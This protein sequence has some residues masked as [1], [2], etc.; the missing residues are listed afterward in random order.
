MISADGRLS[1][2]K[3]ASKAN[4]DW[5]FLQD[6]KKRGRLAADAWLKDELAMVGDRSSLDLGKSFL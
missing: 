5:S 6:L 3:L 4:T 1:D 2:L